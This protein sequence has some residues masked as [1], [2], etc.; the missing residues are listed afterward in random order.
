MTRRKWFLILI[1][2]AYV[3]PFV[4]FVLLMKVWP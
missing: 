3:A 1:F 2:S 4:L